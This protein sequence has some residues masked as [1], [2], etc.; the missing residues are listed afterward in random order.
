VTKVEAGAILRGHGS[1]PPM[2]RLWELAESWLETST[3]SRG[4]QNVL[5]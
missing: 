3:R 5:L 1:A 2:V 4:H